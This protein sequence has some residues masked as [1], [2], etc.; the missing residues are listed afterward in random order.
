MYRQKN[1]RLIDDKCSQLFCDSEI[2]D[3]KSTSHDDFCESIGSE[4]AYKIV[5]AIDNGLEQLKEDL[6]QRPPAAVNRNYKP[7]TLNSNIQGE[8]AKAFPLECKFISGNRFCL[9]INGVMCFFKKVNKYW[10]HSNITT[11]MS[12]M[13]KHQKTT[14]TRDVAPIIIIG[15]KVGADYNS[16]EGVGAIYY[17]HLGEQEWICDIAS[18]ASE[19]VQTSS[20]IVNLAEVK[21]KP[22]VK[23]KVKPNVRK[24]EL[25]NA[26]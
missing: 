24:K 6:R 16:L 13:Y 2:I 3:R 7:N 18:L 9:V 10:Q 15:Y 19:F 4:C 8:I 14:N 25:N 20:N 1:I 23:V 26:L 5:E 21:P 22:E 11:K 12:E 17:N